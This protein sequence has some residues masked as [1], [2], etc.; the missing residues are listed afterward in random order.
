M[1]DWQWSPTLISFDADPAHTTRSTSHHII[2]VR[3]E[4]RHQ[5]ERSHVTDDRRTS[6][7]LSNHKL[8]HTLSS[9]ATNTTE[10]HG[11]HNSTF[12]PLFH[13]TGIGGSASAIYNP[14]NKNNNDYVFK[15]AV[16]NTTTPVPVTLNFPGVQNG[17]RAQ[18]I[19][20]TSP[21]GPNAMN[22]VGGKNVVK[23]TAGMISA[24]A[25]GAFE[26]ELAEWSVAVLRTVNVTVK[27]FVGI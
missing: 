25:G 2:K 11:T 16:Y 1:D 12:N 20:L 10:S 7:L 23:R 14:S 9:T 24:G 18:L 4:Q 22:E 13:V 17:D 3:Q 5:P 21:Q 8:T 27:G 15:A 26:F 19:V 6:Q